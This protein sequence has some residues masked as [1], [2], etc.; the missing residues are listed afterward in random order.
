VPSRT[1]ARIGSVV[2]IDDSREK[3]WKLPAPEKV[4]EWDR[5]AHRVLDV[6]SAEDLWI[7][8]T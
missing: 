7:G 8:K 2:G 4:E 6:A 3:D 1:R 5:G